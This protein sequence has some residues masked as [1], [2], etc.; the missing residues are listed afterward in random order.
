[1]APKSTLSAEDQAVLVLPV[2]VISRVDTARLAR[3]VEA[4]GNY[5][6]QQKHQKKSSQIVLPS[7]SRV[8]GDITASN[9]LDLAKA[10]DRDRLY[11]FLLELKKDAPTIHMSFA[12]EP[13]TLFVAK[14]VTWLRA[15]IHPMLLLDIG[16]QPSIAAGCIIRTTNKYFDCSMRQ[17]LV[18]N[19]PKLLELMRSR[20]H[21]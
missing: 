4:V 9:R 3:E 11:K 14:L 21:A 18:T 5:I 19:K 6:D 10:D 17:H 16:L 2:S 12:V 13:P 15:E 20:Q 8:L 7:L 1:M